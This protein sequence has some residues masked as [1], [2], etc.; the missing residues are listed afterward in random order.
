[1]VTVRAAT[2]DDVDALGA[3]HVRAWQVAYVGMM[4]ADFLAAL[5]AEG[6]AA[7]WRGWFDDPGPAAL[8]DGVFDERVCGFVCFGPHASDGG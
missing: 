4:P 5:R 7:M 2:I 3:L 8:S 6:R 1:M